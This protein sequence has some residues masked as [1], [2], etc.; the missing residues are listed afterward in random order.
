MTIF[1]CLTALGAF[2]TPLTFSSYPRPY[3]PFLNNLGTDCI[4]NT[5]SVVSLLFCL[6][7]RI[8]SP[9][10]GLGVDLTGN[11]AY[12]SSSIVATPT[13]CL[14]RRNLVTAVC[15][16]HSSRFEPSCHNMCNVIRRLDRAAIRPQQQV[17][18]S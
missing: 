10:Y 9:L 1:Y 17:L 8:R 16:F 15:W 6:K 7:A 11:A 4:E 14:L 18:P 2:R 13:L 3:F 12:N 5:V